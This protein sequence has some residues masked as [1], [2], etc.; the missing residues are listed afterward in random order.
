MFSHCQK[1]VVKISASQRNVHVI[2]QGNLASENL[3]TDQPT[4]RSFSLP[5]LA[6]SPAP[7]ACIA[8]HDN[9]PSRIRPGAVFSA[10]CFR[11]PAGPLLASILLARS[12]NF[13]CV[14]FGKR[15]TIPLSVVTVAPLGI[16]DGNG[17][18]VAPSN[19]KPR[20]E[21]KIEI[22]SHNLW[23]VRGGAFF[24]FACA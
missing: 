5:V 10:I 17:L 4:C 15:F 14:G 13:R 7:S 21:G 12:V 8:R 18:P 23:S 24:F 1:G 6:E 9:F 19:Q 3:P 20:T 16:P 11:G 22:V 2:Q